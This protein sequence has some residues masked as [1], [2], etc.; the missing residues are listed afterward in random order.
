MTWTTILTHLVMLGIGGLLGRFLTL[1]ALKAAEE[2]RAHADEPFDRPSNRLMLVTLVAA[3]LLIVLGAQAY[4]ATRNAMSADDDLAK[5]VENDQECTQ[6]WANERDEIRVLR[7]Q[8]NS[9]LVTAASEKDEALDEMIAVII[10][11]NRLGDD[12]TP[13]QEAALEEEFTAALDHY[14]EAQRQLQ[15]ARADVVDA[16]ESYP[17]PNLTDV[18]NR[19]EYR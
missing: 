10:K 11:S 8:A 12:R 13:E 15:E 2:D 4:L 1:R 14:A 3:V 19:P 17:F 6:A 16:E 5:A 7:D 9:A 18:C